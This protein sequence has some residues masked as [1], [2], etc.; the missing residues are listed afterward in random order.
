MAGTKG[1]LIDISPPKQQHFD[2]KVQICFDYIGGSCV[3]LPCPKGFTHEYSTKNN[4]K[5]YG[6]L[7]VIQD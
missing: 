3:N 5:K 6:E 7:N 1:A 2:Q 4:V